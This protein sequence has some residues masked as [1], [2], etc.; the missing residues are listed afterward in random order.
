MKHRLILLGPPGA[1]KGTQAQLLAKQLKVPQIS[2]GAMLRDAV[3]RQTPL[4]VSA[5]KV[6]AA[7][8]LVADAVIIALVEERIAAED[9]EQG[10]VFDGFP[11]TLA[12]AE[13]LRDAAVQIDQVLE[14]VVPDD[15]IV[16]RISGRLVHSA[17]GRTYHAQ[18]APPQRAGYDDITG[19]PLNQREDDSEATVRA[20]LKVYHQQTAPLV[21][22]YRNWSE[23]GDPLAPLYIEVNGCDSVSQVQANM[24]RQMEV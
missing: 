10:F 23:Q 19:E 6:M 7:G 8:E 14:I 2:T 17:S 5:Q 16:R 24:L 22:Y 18:F 13:A 15:E 21:S 20:R 12:Q 4:G 3:A 11:R 1:G 9:C